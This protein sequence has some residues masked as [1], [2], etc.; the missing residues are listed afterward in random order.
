MSLDDD[1]R[2]LL[3]QISVAEE[4]EFGGIMQDAKRVLAKYPPGDRE[5]ANEILQ[6]AIADRRSQLD[7]RD[8]G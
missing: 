8:N 2:A 6:D 7:E 3:Q 4:A 1:M 5:Q